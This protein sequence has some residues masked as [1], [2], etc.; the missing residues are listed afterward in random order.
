VYLSQIAIPCFPY[1]AAAAANDHQLLVVVVCPQIH[2]ILPESSQV[3][4]KGCFR[5]SVA[6]GLSVG[7]L[8]R[9]L[10]GENP[11]LDE[12]DGQ[13]WEGVSL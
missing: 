12:K 5:S 10:R 7:S 3:R 13:G 8:W 4:T 9:H 6:L 1:L 2:L 11:C